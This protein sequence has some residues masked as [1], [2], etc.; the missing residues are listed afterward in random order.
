MQGLLQGIREISPTDPLA[1]AGAS[2]I[3]VAAAVPHCTPPVRKALLQQVFKRNIAWPVELTEHLLKDTD[4]DVR[5]M[6]V[7]RLARDA[8]AKTCARHL[9]LACG[10][11]RIL[12]TTSASISPSLATPSAA[13][14]PS[15]SSTSSRTVSPRSTPAKTAASRKPGSSVHDSQGRPWCQ[16]CQAA[17]TRSK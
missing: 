14:S 3:P 1:L 5:R 4:K 12:R 2:A 16:A 10:A 17:A 9:E 6:A 7:M 8:D 13:A 11:E 15:S